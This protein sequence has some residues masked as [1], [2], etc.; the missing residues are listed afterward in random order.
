MPV[1]GSHVNP[2]RPESEP[3][4][5]QPRDEHEMVQVP[6][7]EIEALVALA[8]LDLETAGA[9]QL[10]ADELESGPLARML[11]SFCDDHRR[12]A[13][14][15]LTFARRHH[16]HVQLVTPDVHGSLL[17]T[18]ACAVGGMAPGAAIE[19]MSGVER[20]TDALYETALRILSDDEALAIVERNRDDERRHH[21]A[22]MTYLA[23][24]GAEEV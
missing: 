17:L 21:E 16:A 18:L 22:L 6:P 14:D 24:R 3:P 15:L 5:P 2:C 13:D 10:T 11:T 12:H 4:S 1:H 23:G 19:T 20:L 7:D 9:Y 8:R